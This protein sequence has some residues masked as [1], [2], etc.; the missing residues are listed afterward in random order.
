MGESKSPQVSR[1]LCVFQHKFNSEPARVVLIPLRYINIYIYIYT[2]VHEQ[3]VLLYHSSSV[4]F[5]TQDALSRNRI[6]SNFIP[7]WHLTA[8]PFSVTYVSSGMMKQMY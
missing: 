3:A 8:Q 2:V 6:P 5:D 1:L 4:L 7:M